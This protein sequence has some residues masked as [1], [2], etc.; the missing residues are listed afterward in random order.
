MPNASC[1][2]VSDAEQYEMSLYHQKETTIALPS[3]FEMR[4]KIENTTKRKT[5][6]I[7]ETNTYSQS[8]KH[9]IN[10]ICEVFK[11][12]SEMHV[13]KKNP[14]HLNRL[15]AEHANISNVLPLTFNILSIL[16]M[17]LQERERK[18]E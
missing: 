4:N 15:K 5:Q 16:F 7:S 11:L 1:G 2:G 17:K 18:R 13:P 9:T 8:F 14:K 12:I 10:L 6:K 3:A